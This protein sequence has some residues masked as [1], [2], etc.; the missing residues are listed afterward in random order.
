MVHG[1]YAKNV[2]TDGKIEDKA[3]NKEVALMTFNKTCN[4]CRQ[5][6]HKEA[7]C[8]AKKHINRQ[9]LPPKEGGKSGK[10]NNQNNS[11]YIKCTEEEVANVATASNKVTKQV[12]N[13]C[14]TGT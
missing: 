4:C 9:V 7:N 11:M 2:T 10:G 5:Q 3:D 8:Y 14:S 13:E 1:L 12:K 6:G